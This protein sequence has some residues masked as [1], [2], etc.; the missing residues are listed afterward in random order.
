MNLLKS[1]KSVSKKISIWVAA[2]LVAVL[3]IIDLYHLL[4]PDNQAR[5]CKRNCA[6]N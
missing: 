4:F 3:G 5:K 6:R 2:G 1:S